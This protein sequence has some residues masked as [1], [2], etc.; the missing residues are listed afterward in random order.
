MVQIYSSS[1]TVKKVLQYWSQ[2]G[3]DYDDEDEDEDVEGRNGTTSK[4][5]KANFI[6]IKKPSSK[7]TESPT[8]FKSLL[9]YPFF[10]M[11]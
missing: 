3:A 9:V 10:K 1:I 2:I 8:L 6:R 4:G 11:C 5:L 7:T